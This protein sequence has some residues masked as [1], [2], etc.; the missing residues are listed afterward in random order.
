MI[1]KMT[2]KIEYKADSIKK[3]DDELENYTKIDHP[4]ILKVHTVY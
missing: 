3:G 2:F 1:M 4:S